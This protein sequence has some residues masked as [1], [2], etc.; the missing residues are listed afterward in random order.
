MLGEGGRGL[1]GIPSLPQTPS[2]LTN[3]QAHSY[4]PPSVWCGNLVFEGR[5]YVATVP[6]SWWE[7]KL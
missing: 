4:R 1:F 6:I 7:K 5:E 3:K 2:L